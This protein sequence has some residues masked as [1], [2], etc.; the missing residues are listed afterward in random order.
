[1]V[2]SRAVSHLL[3]PSERRT[4]CLRTDC[5]RNMGDDLLELAKAKELASVLG[6]AWHAEEWDA[7]SDSEQSRTKAHAQAEPPDIANGDDQSDAGAGPG[8]FLRRTLSGFQRKGSPGGGSNGSVHSSSNGDSHSNSNGT[9][10][11]GHGMGGRR[12]SGGRRPADGRAPGR[13]DPAAVARMEAE[14]AARKKAEE[15]EPEGVDRTWQLPTNVDY[16]TAP[17]ALL[18]ELVKEMPPDKRL[19]FQTRVA[20]ARSKESIESLLQ[21]YA[22]RL[23]SLALPHARSREID[24]QQVKKVRELMPFPPSS[25]WACPSTTRSAPWPRMIPLIKMFFS[26]V[27]LI[28]D[29][30]RALAG[31]HGRQGVCVAGAFFLPPPQALVEVLVREEWNK[32]RAVA[33]TSE[34]FKAMSRTGAGGD[35]YFALVALFCTADKLVVP[36]HCQES[37]ITV[38][39]VHRPSASSA[40]AGGGLSSHWPGKAT[41]DIYLRD[42]A[43]VTERGAG[44]GAAGADASMALHLVRVKAVVV[45]EIWD[46]TPPTLRFLLDAARDERR[47]SAGTDGAKRLSGDRP[48]SGGRPGDPLSVGLPPPAPAPV[49]ALTRTKR[50]MCVTVVP[51]PS[52]VSEMVRNFSRKIGVDVAGPQ[53]PRVLG[54]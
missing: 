51:E 10:G 18:R 42:G 24:L 8:G 26:E 14:A 30:C 22:E 48:T 52:A 3:L 41:F 47:A 15:E 20:N 7:D 28:A 32:A 17:A 29:H 44:N 39:F 2:R 31:S 34:I 9:G 5:P 46:D 40:G 53:P 6:G 16:Y 1:P 43:A 25:R 27:F 35:A 4:R 13:R 54:R 33:T 23:E 19:S 38:E 50:R 36:V 12:P 21:D 11:G 49:L 37:P 45:E